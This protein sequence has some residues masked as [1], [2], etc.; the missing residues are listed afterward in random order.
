MQGTY[1]TRYSSLSSRAGTWPVVVTRQWG[2]ACLNEP[3]RYDA[4]AEP[5]NNMQQSLGQ[6]IKEGP[7]SM[8]VGSGWIG[9][10]WIQVNQIELHRIQV[11]LIGLHRIQVNQ[12]GLH[13][14]H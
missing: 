8:A 12:I 2:R 13:R 7:S 10:E 6:M 9:L 1:H 4:I 3:R 5:K 14:I 11:N